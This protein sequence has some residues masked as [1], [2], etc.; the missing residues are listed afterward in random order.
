MTT[1]PF[2]IGIIQDHATADIGSNVA[3]AVEL[4]R[5]AAARGAQIICLKELFNS[6]YFCKSQQCDRFDLAEPI[7]GPSTE[8]MQ[9]L[10]KELEVVIVVPLFERQAAG[11][12]RNSAAVIDADGSLLGAYRKMHIPDDPMFNEKYYFTPGDGHMDFHGETPGATNGWRVWKT[13]YAN[14]GV[15]ICWDQWYPEAARIT[16]LLGAD[17]LFYPTAIGWHPAE[18]DEWGEAQVQAWRTMQR[19]H[20]IANGVYVASPNRV[21][22]EDEPGTNGIEFFGHSFIADPFGR[23]VADA[24]TGQEILIHT[25]EPALME[26][27]RRNWPFLRDR[28]IDAY[29]PILQRYI[30]VGQ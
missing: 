14:V 22:H 18:K 19:S 29:G 13:R 6:E 11:V 26:T 10:A 1:Q 25:C 27:V 21:G 23:I 24:G 8:V 2:T 5:D 28:R 20:A 15:L 9:A 7:P 12:Y 4:V 17:V 3:R 30:G 16:S